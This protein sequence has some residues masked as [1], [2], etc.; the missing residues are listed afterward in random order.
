MSQQEYSDPSEEVEYL[1][2][3]DNN[4]ITTE[5]ESVQTR[6]ETPEP[7]SEVVKIEEEQY[8]YEAETTS[9]PDNSSYHQTVPNE[10]FNQLQRNQ[11]TEIDA[12]ISSIKETLMSLPNLLR[13]KAKRDISMLVSDFEI[14]YLESLD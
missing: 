3:T 7:I 4:V 2:E 9:N 13:A 1:T 14:K 11:E 6:A 12:W 8:Y 10:A 5:K